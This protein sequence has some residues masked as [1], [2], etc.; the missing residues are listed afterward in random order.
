MENITQLLTML[1]PAI[2]AM[3]AMYMTVKALISKEFEKKEL[4]LKAKNAEI[5]LPIR[6]Q[7]YERMALFLERIAPANLIVRVNDPS[8]NVSDLH[9][10]LVFEIREEYNHNM[11]QQVYMSDKAWELTKTAMDQITQIINISAEATPAEA[12]GIELAKVVVMQMQ[13]LEQ[14][15]IPLAQLFIKEELKK[16]F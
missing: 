12:P 13:S 11:S 8:F 7:A 3:V 6:L 1:L 2:I 5:T 9:Q 4:D 10:R 14:D 16:L 15:P